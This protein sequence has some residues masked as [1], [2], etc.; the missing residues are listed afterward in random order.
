MTQSGAGRSPVFPSA[1]A[2]GVSASTWG[3]ESESE[4]EPES[5]ASPSVSSCRVR[6]GNDSRSGA[7]A[8]ASGAWTGR[9]ASPGDVAWAGRARSQAP[10]SGTSPSGVVRRVRT[11]SPEVPVAD[12]STGNSVHHT[13][14][15]RRWAVRPARS[16]GSPSWAE[17]ARTTGTLSSFP[18]NNA[19]CARS[20]RNS[21]A[22]TRCVSPSKDSSRRSGALPSG[23]IRTR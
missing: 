14:R 12:T 3:S 22:V 6:A 2:S 11:G 18:V 13:V 23:V 1:A 17:K 7:A 9:G 4:S 19:S 20:S 10:A 16:P 21:P 15:P 5:V 8:L